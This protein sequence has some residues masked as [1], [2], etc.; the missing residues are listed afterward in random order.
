MLCDLLTLKQPLRTS[1][2][3]TLRAD[4]AIAAN[5]PRDYEIRYNEI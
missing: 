4:S 3:Q 5:V 2:K 1:L